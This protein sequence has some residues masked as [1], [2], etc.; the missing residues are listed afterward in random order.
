MREI[1]FRGIS[2]TE[3][4]WIYGCLLDFKPEQ[5]LFIQEWDFMLNPN[6]IKS[7]T[8]GQYTGLKDANGNKIF[9]GDVLEDCAGGKYTIVYDDNRMSFALLQDKIKWHIESFK[10]YENLILDNMKIIGNIYDN[11]ELIER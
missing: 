2:I 1:E 5:K 6:E 8:L 9:E 4:K 11:P 3:N 10:D 7:N